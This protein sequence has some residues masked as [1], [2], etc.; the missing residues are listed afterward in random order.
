MKLQDDDTEDIMTM[1]DADE[2]RFGLVSRPR[3]IPCSST[4]T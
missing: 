3:K 2:T 4:L 1:I